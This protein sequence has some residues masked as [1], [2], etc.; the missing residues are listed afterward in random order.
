MRYL[1]TSP[2][3]RAQLRLLAKTIVGLGILG[4][5]A[6][7][8]AAPASAQGLYVQAPGFEFGIGQPYYGRPYYGRAWAYEGRMN[9]HYEPRARAE[10]GWHTWDRY[11][12]RWD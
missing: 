4:A 11:G 9:R 2:Y 1:T 5:T 6:L 12:L 8:P 7:G 3:D 10:R